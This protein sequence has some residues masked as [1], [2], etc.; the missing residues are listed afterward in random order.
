MVEKWE[1]RRSQKKEDWKDRRGEC[2]KLTDQRLK[3]EEA[4]KGQFERACYFGDEAPGNCFGEGVE[5]LLGL[6]TSGV[7][8]VNSALH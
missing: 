8:L 2:S 3:Q 5:T 4:I 7:T 1:R 6:P